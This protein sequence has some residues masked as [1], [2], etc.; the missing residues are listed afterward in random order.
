MSA[1]ELLFRHALE[2]GEMAGRATTVDMRDVLVGLALLYAA[3][4]GQQQT[5]EAATIARE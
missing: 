3:I 2:Y 4:A 5:L 1:S